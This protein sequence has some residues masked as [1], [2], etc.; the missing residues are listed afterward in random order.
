LLLGL[1]GKLV[2]TAAPPATFP[3]PPN[4]ATNV[5]ANTDLNWSIADLD[6][7]QNGGFETGNTAGWS[8]QESGSGVIFID[9]DDPPAEGVYS[10]LIYA[11]NSPQGVFGVY[12]DVSI[13][14]SATRILFRW[15]DLA[16]NTAPDF[17]NDPASLQGYRVELRNLNNSLRQVLFTTQPG[18]PSF[19]NWTKHTVDLSNFQGQTVRVAIVAYGST[20]YMIMLLDRVSLTVEAPA[21]LSSDVLWNTNST[22]GGANLLGT[23]TNTSWELPELQPATTY[24]WRILTHLDGSQNNGPVWQFTTAPRGPIDHFAWN[25]ISSPQPPGSSLVVTLTAQDTRNFT[26]TNFIGPASL[27][28]WSLQFEPESHS[29][30]ADEPYTVYSSYRNATVG[31]AFTPST[32]LWVKALRAFSGDQ[33]SLWTEEGFLLARQNIL[34]PEA[35]WTEVVLPKPIPLQAF[36]RYRLGVFSKS[37]R[38][39]YARYDGL[40]AFAHGTLDQAYEGLGNAF[41]QNPHPVR[42]W[43]VDLDYQLASA[44]SLP[45]TPTRTGN[46]VNGVWSGSL[47][48]PAAEASNVVFLAVTEAGP[49]GYGNLFDL[50]ATVDLDSDGMPDDWESVHGLNPN[51]PSDAAADNDQDG[52]TNLQEYL[53]GTDPNLASSVFQ[54]V[55]IRVEGGDVML[56]F[57]TVAGRTYR[58]ERTSNLNTHTWTI[59]APNLHGTGTD[60]EITD[61]DVASSGT[62]FYRVSVLP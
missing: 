51:D 8:R 56:R 4:L 50:V 60:L 32:N 16:Q 58:V 46:F 28:A 43:F 27:S 35:N 39:Q 49:L 62:A 44:E 55:S 45:L 54:V 31:Y 36:H 40:G 18:D 29:L 14:I 19:H 34:P 30:L 48:L 2:W 20:G 23:T 3:S 47:D 17:S 11:V 53:A 61:A 22:V 5:S 52:Q 9:P 59:I 33:I 12:Q 26:D 1:S 41:P 21:R 38:L 7:I 37:T 24:Y 42:W 10:L 6:L 57:H 13:P 15:S 25:L